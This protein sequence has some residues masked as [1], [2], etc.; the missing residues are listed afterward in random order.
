LHAHLVTLGTY[1]LLIGLYGTAGLACNYP[2]WFGS[3]HSAFSE[4]CDIMI[5]GSTVK[6]KTMESYLLNVALAYSIILSSII[7][8][9]WAIP[10]M[11][12]WDHGSWY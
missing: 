4:L 8:N 9:Y 3:V 7:K 5:Y 10:S 12:Q 1:F 6:S 11:N 2:I